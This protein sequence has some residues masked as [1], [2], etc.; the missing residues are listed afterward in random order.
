MCILEECEK[1]CCTLKVCLKIC[2]TLELREVSLKM[3]E[4]VVFE[5]IC[6]AMVTGHG[7]SLFWSVFLLFGKANPSAARRFLRFFW[8]T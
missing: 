6:Q 4:R 3:S 8:E 7:S 5:Q 2:Y 1:I